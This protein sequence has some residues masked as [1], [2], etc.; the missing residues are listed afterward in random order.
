MRPQRLRREGLLVKGIVHAPRTTLLTLTILVVLGAALLPMIARKGRTN[1][2]SAHRARDPLA[3]LDAPLP[4]SG[5]RATVTALDPPATLLGGQS[6]EVAVRVRNDGDRPWPATPPGG[7]QYALHLGDRWLDPRGGRPPLDDARA[8][9][10][11]PLY[12]GEE[13][14][15]PLTIT[16]P[17]TAGL[18]TLEIDLVQGGAAW[19]GANG[20]TPARIIV[21]VLP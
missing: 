1:D 14:T 15:V 19:A 4:A 18:Y 10:P 17:P 7:G 5:F 3:P 20:G 8:P 2:D 13:A 9:L 16:A 11:H 12:P 21:W 6:V